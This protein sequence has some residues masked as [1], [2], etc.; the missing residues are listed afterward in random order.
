[1][2]DE[3]FIAWLQ[4]ADAIRCALVEVVA[5]IGGVETT[6]YLSSQAFVSRASDTPASTAYLPC[7]DGGVS[8]TESLNLDGQPS[9]SYGDIELSNTDGSLDAWLGY[10]WA[11]RHVK[12]YIGDVRWPRADFRKVFDG[13]VAD[14][15]ARSPEVLNITLL[16]K[17]QRL[18]RPVSESLLGGASVN[19]DKL[20]PVVLGEVLNMEP[21]LTDAATL[22]YQVHGGAIEDVLEVRDNGAP[23]SI[24]K[25][26]ATGKFRLTAARVGQITA[27][28]QGDKPGG[29]YSNT[30]AG[31]VQRLATGYGP[32]NTRFSGADLDAAQLADFAA[33]NPQPVGLAITDRT[34]VLVA[35]QQLAASV[36]AHVV[37]TTLGL[38]RLVQIALPA[39]GTPIAIG[40]SDYEQRSLR[41]E[42]R[43]PVKAA[44]KLAYDR[45]YVPQS[46]GMATGLPDSSLENLRAEW[47]YETSTDATTQATYKLDTEPPAEETCLKRQADAATESGRRLVLRKTPRNIYTVRCYSHLLLTELG[48]AAVLSGARYGLAGGATGQV[49]RIR[50]HWLAGRID[51]GVLV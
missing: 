51:I 33:A 46:N 26:L 27:D 36:G 45:N 28:V 15:D 20:V 17:L 44:V 37:V 42:E 8:F 29:T 38:L 9:I 21:L 4:S 50:R 31:L 6:L 2:T 14:L 40:P 1:M 7:I 23:R 30:I 39:L 18:N 13:V 48:N 11:N 16:D 34:N 12:V 43:V 41:L 5:R 22:E 19:K 24:T 25:T 47:F 35:C 32:A 3:Q 49:L 10:V